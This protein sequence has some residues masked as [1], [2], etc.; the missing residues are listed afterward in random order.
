[1]RNYG[2]KIGLLIAGSSG[3]AIDLSGF[4]VVFSVEKTAAE[5]PNKAKIE[6]WNLSDT[7]ASMLLTGKMTRIV[8]QAGYVDNSAVLF[9]GNIIAAKRIRQ[10]TDVIVS[11][12]AGDGDKSYSFAVVQQSIASGS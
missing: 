8:L 12:D 3:D 11:I 4:R 6:I 2:R 5:Q 1:M 7:T 10:G 9:D